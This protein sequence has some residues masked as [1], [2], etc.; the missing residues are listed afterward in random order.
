MASIKKRPDGKYR[1][2]YRDEAGKEHAKHFVR[3]VDAQEWLDEKTAAMVTGQYV[4]PNAGKITFARFF[5]DWAARQ[6]WVTGT[7]QA[8]RLAARSVTFGSVE[9]RALRRSHVEQWVKAM[10][11]AERGEGKPRGLAPGTIRTRYNN[12][13]AVL[14]AAVRDRLI[15]SDPSEGVKLPR[16]RRAEVAMT[17]PTPVQVR[18]LLLGSTGWFQ[19]FLALAAFAGLRLGEAAALKVS[20]V[21]F[22]GR[23]LD[24][25]RQVQRAVRGSVEIRAPKYGSERTVYLAE[26]LVQVLAEHIKEHRLGEDRDRWLFVGENGDPP[27]QNTV[28]Y[29][30][31]KTCRDAGVTGLTL[32]DLRHFYA[33]GL[34]A[35]GC[36]VVTVQRA[37][38]H[39]SATVTLRTYAHLW[40]T[41][42]DRTRKAASALIAETLGGSV[43]SSADQART[44]TDGNP[45]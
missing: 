20:D 25:R 36:D 27:H 31:R 15:V 12:V 44:G 18:E 21:N 23:S 24:V 13:R 1:A 26:E 28:G 32:H 42:E 4:D 43:G 16:T 30:W 22:L 19:A 7:E 37:L 29:W 45:R 6:V 33:S 40:P 3:K 9:L 5:E 17:L 41:A 34:I 14:R 8:M 38:G 39:A 35:Q 10:Q 11:T 2:R